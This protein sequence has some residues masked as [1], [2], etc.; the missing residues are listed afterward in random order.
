MEIKPDVRSAD[1]EICSVVPNANNLSEAGNNLPHKRKLKD[2]AGSF[3]RIRKGS[4]RKLSEGQK[5]KKEK[6]AARKERKA[7]KTLAIVLGKD[8]WWN[9]ILKL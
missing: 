9:F 8:K 2:I 6:N 4:N 7:T 5:K 1:L 3:F